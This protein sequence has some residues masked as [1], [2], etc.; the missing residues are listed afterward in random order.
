MHIK[1]QHIRHKGR[2]RI[3][4]KDSYDTSF[5]T[6]V[7][8]RPCKQ[9][10]NPNAGIKDYP[11]RLREYQPKEYLFEGHHS[12]RTTQRYTKVAKTAQQKIK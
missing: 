2:A 5:D 4:L 6:Y 9:A 3:L 7:M 8:G 1:L 12:I 10:I 11:V